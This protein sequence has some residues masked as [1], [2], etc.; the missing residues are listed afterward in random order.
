MLKAETWGC[1]NPIVSRLYGKPPLL[2]KDMRVQLVVYE[3]DIEDVRRVVPE[4]MELRN[5]D[6]LGFGV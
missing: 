2:W 6:C 4:P 1:T 3:T 5:R